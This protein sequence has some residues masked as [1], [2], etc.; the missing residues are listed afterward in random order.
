MVLWGKTLSLPP[1][2]HN[3]SRPNFRFWFSF[4]LFSFFFVNPN[5]F[6]NF[7]LNKVFSSPHLPQYTKKNDLFL[8]RDTGCHR[9]LMS[10]SRPSWQR[11]EKNPIG[12]TECLK[13]HEQHMES[14]WW[15]SRMTMEGDPGT[16]AHDPSHEDIFPLRTSGSPVTTESSQ[17]TV[18]TAYLVSPQWSHCVVAYLNSPESNSL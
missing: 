13:S 15:P 7:S 6:I 2:P 17:D 10:L 3:N 9:F 4:V 11:W 16:K 5:F 1:F 18:T 14:Q 12:G 8:G